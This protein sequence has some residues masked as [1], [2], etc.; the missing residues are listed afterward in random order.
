MISN[1]LFLSI[2]GVGMWSPKVT[3]AIIARGIKQNILC[4]Y[5]EANRPIM[6]F[7]L[8]VH[9]TCAVALLADIQGESAADLCAATT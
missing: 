3:K 8:K 9:S 6:V 4:A 7:F 5:R 2:A 1:C